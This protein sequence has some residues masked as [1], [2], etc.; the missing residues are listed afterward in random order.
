MFCL[1]RK[2][3]KDLQIVSRLPSCGE[4]TADLRSPRGFGLRPV[5]AVVS[6]QMGHSGHQGIIGLWLVKTA[7]G[8]PLPS[9]AKWQKFEGRGFLCFYFHFTLNSGRRL[10]V[11]GERSRLAYSSTRGLTSACSDE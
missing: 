10:F 6:R 3:R 7:G 5:T 2:V 8:R 11:R 4:V 1:V 9:G